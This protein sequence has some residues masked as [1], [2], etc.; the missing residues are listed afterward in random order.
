MC[1]DHPARRAF[2]GCMSAIN[3]E[4]AIGLGVVLVGCAIAFGV[5]HARAKAKNARD[6]REYLKERA[7][8]Y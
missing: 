4:I 6:R 1:C 2:I 7:R 5:I 8:R 3:I